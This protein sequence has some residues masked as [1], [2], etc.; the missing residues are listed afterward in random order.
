MRFNR[1][2]TQYDSTLLYTDPDA[3][4]DCGSMINVY[5]QDIVS[6]NRSYRSTTIVKGFTRVIY[7]KANQVTQ[8]SRQ[9]Y[10]WYSMMN[11]LQRYL[12]MEQCLV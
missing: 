5:E 8:A 2:V 4:T 11:Q 10:Y 1:L 9:D 7:F 12:F 3:Y 6:Y